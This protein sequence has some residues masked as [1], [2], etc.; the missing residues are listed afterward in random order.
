MVVL[1]EQI[2]I[3]APFEKLCWWADH[4][5]TEFVKWS[6][7]HLACQ[8][9]DG[10]VNAGDRVR[11][12]EIVMGIDYDVTGTIIQAERDPEHFLF[13][14][15]SDRKTAVITFEGHRTPAGCRF[16]HTEAFGV[17]T[18]VIGPVINFLIFKVLY[19]K[20]AD[21]Q[22]IREDM[23]LDNQYLADI[24]TEGRYPER[25]PVEMLK[26]PEMKARVR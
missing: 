14:F 15:E 21:W 16:V 2:D 20:K 5:E 8:L 17:Q 19:R 3:S 11:F 26:N 18:P 1:R 9:F 23:I 6:P 7:Y 10:G 12:Y 13:R 25:M 4:F 24:L 22:L